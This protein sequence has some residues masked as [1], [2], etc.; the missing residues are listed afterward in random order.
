[1]TGVS[2]TS[3][4]GANARYDRARG[5]MNRHAAYIVVAY[6]AGAAR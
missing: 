5:S 4:G 6:L 3:V 2:S 1:M